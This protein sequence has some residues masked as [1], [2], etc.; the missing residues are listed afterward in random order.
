[1]LVDAS[2]IVPME[3]SEDQDFI[4]F[5]KEHEQIRTHVETLL[6]QNN[7]GNSSVLQSIEKIVCCS[8]SICCL[9]LENVA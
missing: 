8:Y 6:T 9:Y 1:M 7:N 2:K 4:S 5:F 3:A